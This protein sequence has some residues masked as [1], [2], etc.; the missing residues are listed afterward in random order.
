MP[1]SG[2]WNSNNKVLEAVRPESAD[3][4]A[5]EALPTPGIALI[6]AAWQRLFRYDFF[7]SYAWADGRRYAEALVRE[8][9]AAPYRYR[10]FIDDREMGGGE[11]WR[12]S[13]RK[14][15]RRSSVMVLVASPRA[16]ESDN[17]FDEV[18][19]FTQRR[20]PLIPICFGAD[21]ETLPPKHR[22]YGRL[23]ERLRI[24]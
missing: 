4:A 5:A 17:V 24:S 9:A 23:E 14:A 12:A 10:C 16:L 7:I 8:L 18:N 2:L 11:P 1:W 22:L 19:T 21:V 6:R 3:Q 15:L 13:V 20:R